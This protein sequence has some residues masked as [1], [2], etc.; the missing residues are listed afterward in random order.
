MGEKGASESRDTKH[1][2]PMV[3][4]RRR[5]AENVNVAKTGLENFERKF[6]YEI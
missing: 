6:E 1:Q 3:S 5:R 4:S 2:T